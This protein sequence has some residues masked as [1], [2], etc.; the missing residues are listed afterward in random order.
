MATKRK[1][2]RLIL[3]S[4]EI[5]E[6]LNYCADN[7]STVSRN[8]KKNDYI[9]GA[10]HCSDYIIDDIDLD[11]ALGNVSPG[12]IPCKEIYNHLG[13]NFQK[14]MEVVS[15]REDSLEGGTYAL[16]P[17]S[18]IFHARAGACLEASILVQM[19]AQRLGDSFLIHGGMREIDQGG[20]EDRKIS[21]NKDG[22]IIDRFSGYHSLG[23]AYNIIFKEGKPFLVDS[24]NPIISFSGV[25]GNKIKKSPYI[26]PLWGINNYNGTLPP[27]DYFEREKFLKNNP[28]Q[29]IFL[30]QEIYNGD[31]REYYFR[32]PY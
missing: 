14:K 6:F 29:F 16:I 28:Q 5:K 20:M 23:H 9:L 24:V 17:F 27:K 26:I 30:N 31:K 18:E 12:M 7:S 32:I 22:K 4:Q 8:I 25:F 21:L 15:K 19:A 10:G 13:P 3:D 2:K 1:V 11:L